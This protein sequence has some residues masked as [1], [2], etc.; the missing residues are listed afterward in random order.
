V[1][2]GLGTRGPLIAFTPARPF[3]DVD[4]MVRI[5]RASAPAA[6]LLT[7]P[8]LAGCRVFGV[9]HVLGADAVEPSRVHPWHQWP[10]RLGMF[11]VTVPLTIVF[12][13]FAAIE[14]LTTG[15]SL[16]RKQSP[17]ITGYFVGVP[18]TVGAYALATPFLLGGL[19]WERGTAAPP[20]PDDDDDAD[21][22][23]T[24]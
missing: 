21:D 1:A 17:G 12:A 23:G 22:T 3:A 6:L 20:P 16:F 15:S 7:L 4:P 8:W 19:P 18:A 5:R 10:A 11:A 24:D 9:D 14:D 13:P 2:A